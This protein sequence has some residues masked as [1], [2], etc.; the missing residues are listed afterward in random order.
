MNQKRPKHLALHLIRFPLP[1]IV[2]ILHR[3]S[4]V[5]L[6]LC[7]PLLLWTLQHSLRSI[8][9]FTELSGIV[10]HPLS[11][12]ILIAVLWTFLH[13]LCAGIRYLALDLDYGVRLAQARTS[14]KWVLAVSVS[15][16]IFLG[17]QLW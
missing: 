8:E 14:S 6:F 12:L 13:H 4:G 17:V 15:L 11:K 5:L 3:A 7:L 9:T 10:Q 16:T 1:A 2:S